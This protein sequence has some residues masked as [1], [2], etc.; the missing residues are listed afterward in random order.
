[1]KKLIFLYILFLFSNFPAQNGKNISFKPGE[2]WKDTDGVHINAHGGGILFDKGTYYWFGEF[3]GD[4]N[5]AQVGVTVYSGKDL[6]NWKNE[7]VALKVSEDPNSEITKGSIIER[8]KVIY[9]TKTKKYV[10]W[11]HLELKG[12]GYEAA[13][14]GLAVSDK[15]A[16]PYRFIRS[17]R[18]NVGNWPVDFPD[19]QKRRVKGEDTIK[20]WT[21]KWIEAIQD[22]M[23]L[24]RDFAVGQMSRDMQLFVDDDGKA[25]HI[26]SAEE[27]GT[28]HI[29]LLTDDYQDFTNEFA[30]MMP[31]DFNEAPAIFKKDGMY[32][33]IASGTTG[34]KPNPARSFRAKN[35]FGP[36]ESLGNPAVGPKAETTFDSQSTYILPVQ[37]KKDQFI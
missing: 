6:Y 22:G 11:F 30:V 20:S 28:L 1:M 26:H 35:I 37:G 33:M 10:M 9:N 29:S 18:P 2:I 5:D 36:W 25:Y 4:T 13:R 27:N 14:T 8:P 23:F 16:G 15:P 21:P 31:S 7:G 12:R 32:Y 24:R 34:W 3:K 19:S 17:Y